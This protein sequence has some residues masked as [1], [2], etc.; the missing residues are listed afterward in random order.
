MVPYR[1]ILSL[2]IHAFLVLAARSDTDR[3]WELPLLPLEGFPNADNVHFRYNRNAT[4]DGRSSKFIPNFVWIAFAEAPEDIHVDLHTYYMIKNN[5]NW[6]FSLA[7]NE[8]KQT[9]IDTVFKGTSVQWAYN[10]INNKLGNSKAGAYRK[11]FEII[12]IY[13]ISGFNSLYSVSDLWRFC[14]LYVYG[15]IYLDDDSDLRLPFDQGNTVIFY[16]I[17]TFFTRYYLHTYLGIHP[18]DKIIFGFERNPYTG[19]IIM[20]LF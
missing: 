16:N 8:E 6:K 12:I 18:D 10:N 5:P 3:G 13:F 4:G 1:I 20:N 17:V 14:I 2:L 11:Y 15:G 19:D 9:F 7:G